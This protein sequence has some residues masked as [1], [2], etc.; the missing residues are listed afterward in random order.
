VLAWA[1]LMHTAPY[2]HE[3]KALITLDLV[4]R[5]PQDFEEKPHGR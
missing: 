4:V 2:P 1:E 3:I 5:N